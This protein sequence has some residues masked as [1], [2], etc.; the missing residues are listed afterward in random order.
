MTLPAAE[1][2]VPDEP[3]RLRGVPKYRA[4]KRTVEKA[5][6]TIRKVEL[7]S[8]LNKGDGSLL[9][10]LLRTRVE[11]PQGRPLPA[12]ALLRGHATVIV[13]VVINKETGDRKFLMLRQ[14]RIGHGRDTLEF[15]AGM[16]D[17]DVDDAQGTAL[18][19][20]EEETGLKAARE[21][22]YP[23][24]DKPLYTSSGLDDEAIHYF[25][26]DLELSAQAFHALEGG[27]TGKAEEHE[28]IRLGL[29]DYDSALPEVDSVQVRLGFSLYFQHQRRAARS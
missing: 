13:T 15:P 16:L 3:E 28:Y 23:L 4:W 5:G 11:D 22:L 10:A 26:C 7:L 17:E 20:L 2:P 27:E 1:S 18:R 19:E 14:R 29:W 25:G 21:Q 9:F 24:C 8:E 6:C 12:Y